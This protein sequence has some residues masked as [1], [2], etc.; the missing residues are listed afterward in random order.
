M[1]RGTLAAAGVTLSSSAH[2]GL[3]PV[4]C[5]G[6]LR[7]WLHARL[8][9]SASPARGT[10]AVR[11]TPGG[12]GAHG[13]WT[14]SARVGGYR[15]F[16]S[17]AEAE[18]ECVTRVAGRP[19]DTSDMTVTQLREELRTHGMSSLPVGRMRKAA[20]V[21]LLQRARDTTY[22][23]GAH[24]GGG[25]MKNAHGGNSQSVASVTASV[26][27]ARRKPSS[28]PSLVLPSGASTSIQTRRR[29]SRPKRPPSQEW[30][31]GLS[32]SRDAVFIADLPRR[33]TRKCVRDLV[34]AAGFDV[35]SVRTEHGV[36]NRRGASPME[37]A[38]FKERTAFVVVKMR[39]ERDAAEVAERLDE[40][41]CRGGQFRGCVLRVRPHV[42]D[43]ERRGV[44]VRWGLGA[45]GSE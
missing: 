28:S 24:G 25:G 40:K 17:R 43:Y 21:S 35:A 30:V 22:P 26:S 33:V 10:T 19:H 2:P 3:S 16:T 6:K 7:V 34:T 1:R 15:R 18:V 36:S 12:S 31:C 27:N 39:S 14:T 38:Y 45:I 29:R 11:R 23:D 5:V 37:R 20:L 9:Y 13:A 41:V 8:G 32:V 44:E 4:A 42:E